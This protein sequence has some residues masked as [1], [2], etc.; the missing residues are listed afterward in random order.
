[1]YTAF[2]LVH[3]WCWAIVSNLDLAI[4]YSILNSIFKMIIVSGVACIWVIGAGADC[5]FSTPKKL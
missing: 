1:M 2:Y 4:S 5:N 3:F